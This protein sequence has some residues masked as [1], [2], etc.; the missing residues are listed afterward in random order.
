MARPHYVRL[1]VRT[2]GQQGVEFVLCGHKSNERKDRRTWC[3]LTCLLLSVGGFWFFSSS[4]FPWNLARLCV[5]SRGN[6]IVEGGWLRQCCEKTRWRLI[7]VDARGTRARRASTQD[8]SQWQGPEQGDRSS[9]CFFELVGRPVI[10]LSSSPFM[11]GLL[12]QFVDLDVIS[13]V[14]VT[15]AITFSNVVYSLVLMVEGQRDMEMPF[16]VSLQPHETML[17]RSARTTSGSRW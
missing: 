7:L 9:N 8:V 4:F 3:F 14:A 6:V 13:G 5:T 1:H 11:R 15:E 16:E 10:V 2:Y 17:P 12:R